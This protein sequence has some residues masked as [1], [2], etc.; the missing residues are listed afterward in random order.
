MY[1][2]ACNSF[3]NVYCCITVCSTSNLRVSVNQNLSPTSPTSRA[4]PVTI[5]QEYHADHVL[6]IVAD[7]QQQTRVCNM[8]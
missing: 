8:S 6:V 7:C 3:P 2:Y 5:K 1:M 4:Y